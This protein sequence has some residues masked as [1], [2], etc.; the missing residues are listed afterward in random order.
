MTD[1]LYVILNLFLD[2]RDRCLTC[3]VAKYLCISRPCYTERSLV[4]PT[5]RFPAQT[6][7]YCYSLSSQTECL[8][9]VITEGQEWVFVIIDQHTGV[10]LLFFYVF[11]SVLSSAAD[12][13]LQEDRYSFISSLL[14]PSR[15][16]SWA[17]NQQLCILLNTT[18]VRNYTISTTGPHKA[19]TNIQK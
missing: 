8:W 7:T 19:S 9:T 15:G 11:Y 4:K 18:A 16:R 1:S 5:C 6:V 17:S 13:F 2:D 12:S 14:L 10:F 3:T